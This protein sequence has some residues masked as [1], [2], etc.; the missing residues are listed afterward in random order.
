[1]LRHGHEAGDAALRPRGRRQ[2]PVCG[3][4]LIFDANQ[5]FATHRCLAG[6]KR[7]REP[8]AV[9]G[10]SPSWMV[11]ADGGAMVHPDGWSASLAL[12]LAEMGELRVEVK[13]GEP[14]GGAQP[15]LDAIALVDSRHR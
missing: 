1:M 15:G 4:L 8:R 7:T 3:E 6:Q 12:D 9:R 2:S 5:Q 10:G 11:G 14:A 13:V